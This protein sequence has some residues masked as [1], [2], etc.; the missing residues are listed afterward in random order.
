VGQVEVVLPAEPTF[1]VA[2]HISP[3]GLALDPVSPEVDVEPVPTPEATAVEDAP[4]EDNLIIE[5]APGHGQ[6]GEEAGLGDDIRLILLVDDR[7]LRRLTAP[8]LF[9]GEEGARPVPVTDDGA[10]EQDTPGDGIYAV[11][12]ETQRAEYLT[13]RLE[14]AGED[15]GSLAVFLPSTRE[16]IIR[17]RT[18]EGSPGIELSVEPLPLAGTDGPGAGGPAGASRLARVLWVAIVLFAIAFG[19]LRLVLW[20]I[21]KE[22]LEPLLVQL[23]TILDDEGAGKISIS[24][25]RKT[26]QDARAILAAAELRKA[27]SPAEE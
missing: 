3:G 7:A 26:A 11:E 15:V 25:L 18:I 14:D 16:A 17:L 5:A 19:Y 24:E 12:L 10:I 21:W 13:L 2:L 27:E 6:G 20:R 1:E 23:R 22:E 4:G 8:T 9:L